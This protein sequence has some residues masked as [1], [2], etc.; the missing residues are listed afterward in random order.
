MG[1]L[2]GLEKLGLGNFD[3]IEVFDNLDERKVAGGEG[4]DK[5]VQPDETDYLFDKKYNC[6]VCDNTFFSKTVRIGKVKTVAHDSDLRPRYSGF[7]ALKYD[8]VSCPLCGFSAVT[9]FFKPLAP[10]QRRWLKEQ[11]AA[12]FKGLGQEP[13]TYSYDESIMRHKLA[14][15]CAVVKRAK[16]SE[17]AYCCLKLAWL[18]RGKAEAEQEKETKKQ[19]LMEEL[20]MIEKA[21]VGFSDAFSKESFPMCGMDELTVT[22]LVADLA[23]Q[24]CKYD[25]ALRYVGRIIIAKNANERIKDKARTLRDLINEEKKSQGTTIQDS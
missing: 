8:I 18:Y 22:Y 5:E 3:K 21:Y 24:L 10:S 11:I 13:E 15:V 1:L 19:L 7:D 4:F 14:L 9:K 17:R 12:N 16:T 23:R 25:A 2:S 20:A 6:P